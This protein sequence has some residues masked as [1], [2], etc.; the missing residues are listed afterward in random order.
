[1]RRGNWPLWIKFYN[2]SEMYSTLCN[3]VCD[4]CIITVQSSEYTEKYDEKEFLCKGEFQWG[5]FLPSMLI[6]TACDVFPLIFRCFSLFICFS[7]LFITFLLGP[8]NSEH[9]ILNTVEP[10][11]SGHVG[12]ER[13]VH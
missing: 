1:M 4:G 10:P 6:D 9:E 11:N 13:F 3:G 2:E 8:C 5:I 7:Y 12:D